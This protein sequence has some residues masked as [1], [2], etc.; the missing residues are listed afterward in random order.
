MGTRLRA[1]LWLKLLPS[2]KLFVYF[3]THYSKA[4]NTLGDKS[5]RQIT[6]YVQAA[7]CCGA[8]DRFVR[9]G[10]LLWKSCPC[11][12][13]RILR[14]NESHR[15]YLIWFLATYCCDKILSQR[16]RFWQKFPRTH[17]AICRCDV[18]PRH[19]TATCRLMPVP[20]LIVGAIWTGKTYCF[21]VL[22]TLC[23]SYRK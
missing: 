14:R 11:N 23:K 6:P 2:T 17:E 21:P 19:V 1:I 20:T 4:R 9:T 13:N 5:Q 7:T 10:E 12:C 16:R 15:F 22:N 18:S 3:F 8:T